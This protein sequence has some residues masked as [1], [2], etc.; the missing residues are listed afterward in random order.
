MCVV[1]LFKKCFIY[2]KGR[3]DGAGGG[4][5]EQRELGQAKPGSKAALH[6]LRSCRGPS[7]PWLLSQAASRELDQSLNSWNSN[8]CPYGIATLQVEA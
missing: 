7:H 6:L 1:N 5:G 8:S 2:L 4:G 3:V